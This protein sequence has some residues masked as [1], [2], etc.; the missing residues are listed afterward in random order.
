MSFETHQ[1]VRYIILVFLS[2]IPVLVGIFL[3]IQD[4]VYRDFS[5]DDQSIA[6]ELKDDTISEGF[7]L[8][9]IFFGSFIASS[10]YII[11]SPKKLQSLLSCIISIF[12][13]FGVSQSVTLLLKVNI[14]RLRPDFLQRCMPDMRDV[15]RYTQQDIPK[16]GRLLAH[17]FICTGDPKVIREGHFS[18]PSQHTSSISYAFVFVACLAYIWSYTYFFGRQQKK[19]S[20]NKQDTESEQATNQN[21][22]HN[23]NSQRVTSPNKRKTTEQEQQ[24]QRQQSPNNNNN[25]KGRQ[26]QYKRRSNNEHEMQEEGNIRQKDEGDE[27]DHHFD[28]RIGTREG[29][30]KS[31]LFQAS[32]VLGMGLMIISM[33]VAATRVADN[34]HRL[35]DILAGYIIGVLGGLLSGYVLW[36]FERVEKWKETESR[37]V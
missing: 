29:M 31:F 20:V 35:S 25:N 27:K 7:L 30:S 32:S 28:I 33:F 4:P 19:K 3:L 9:I 16:Y 10:I 22:N 8:G 24:I 21:T 34:K 23:Q 2:F 26:S 15:Y 18:F 1:I 6:H 36:I 13:G 17:N 37:V 5:L 11:F 12:F 14:G